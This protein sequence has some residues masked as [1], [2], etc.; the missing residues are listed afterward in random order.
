MYQEVHLNSRQ[1]HSRPGSP[2]VC[3]RSAEIGLGGEVRV[4]AQLCVHDGVCTGDEVFDR[5]RLALDH[6]AMVKARAQLS[7][8][9]GVAEGEDAIALQEGEVCR[10]EAGVEDRAMGGLDADQGGVGAVAS[11]VFAVDEAEGDLAAIGAASE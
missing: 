9:A 2:Q 8:A 11:E 10:L 3:M 6:R 1:A 5:A 7:A 4:A